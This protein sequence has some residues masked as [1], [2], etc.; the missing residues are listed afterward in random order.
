[1]TNVSTTS[2]TTQDYG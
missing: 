1:M 2:T